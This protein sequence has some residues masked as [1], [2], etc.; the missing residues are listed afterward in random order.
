MAFENIDKLPNGP[1][2]LYGGYCSPL[3]PLVL[4]NTINELATELTHLLEVSPIG[5]V[6]VKSKLENMPE[7][8][9]IEPTQPNNAD[10]QAGAKAM[11]DVLSYRAAN[12]WH[13]NPMIDDACEQESK[14]VLSWIKDALEDVSPETISEW[15]SIQ[16]AYD[17]G[18]ADGK[19][20]SSHDKK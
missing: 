15:R 3:H 11:F 2:R 14:L 13:G 5:E 1:W 8:L 4:V 18:V 6:L 16:E 12:N 10:F 7:P 9:D 20:L 17:T 19:S